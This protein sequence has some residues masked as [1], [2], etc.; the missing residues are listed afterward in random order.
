M[1]HTGL[2]RGFVPVEDGRR[3]AFEIDGG[4]RLG[5]PVLL[6]RPLGGTM[7]LWGPFREALAARGRVI[8]FDRAGAGESSDAPPFTTTRDMA[9][10]AAAVLDHLGVAR[11][12]VFGLSL[13]GMVAT[14]LAADAPE[15]VERLCLAS[16][17]D[18][19]LDLSR[20]A[21]ERGASLAGCLFR[22][23][24]SVEACLARRILSRAFRE[25][26]PERVAQIE[27]LAGC[28]SARRAELVKQVV[29][30]ALHRPG[31]ALGRIHAPTLV[32]AGDR[33]E[34]LGHDAQKRLAEAIAGAVLEIVPEAGH[35]LSL[36]RPLFV[37][38]RIGA[39]F[40]GEAPQQDSG[41]RDVPAARRE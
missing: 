21:A 39:F 34:L 6:I 17:P 12:H 10:D 35:D 22:G 27:K 24:G 4:E 25:E 3:L 29:A 13:G 5:T 14:W 41:E 23:A 20:S 28:A 11:A 7:T 31:S 8:A 1:S 38:G 40:W 15:R 37:A 30:A 9:R 26:H 19:G 32:L 18:T 16:T 36:E 2:Q 33:D